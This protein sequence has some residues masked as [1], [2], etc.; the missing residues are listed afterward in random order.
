MDGAFS[1]S[2]HYMRTIHVDG[3]FGIL[4]LK[5]ESGGTRM[6]YQ[7]NDVSV[8]FVVTDKNLKVACLGCLGVLTWFQIS[9]SR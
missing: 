9:K 7:L 3:A 6:G 8:P 5:G 4:K 1:F 2:G